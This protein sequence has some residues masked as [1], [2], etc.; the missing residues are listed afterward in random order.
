MEADKSGCS[1]LRPLTC[2]EFIRGMD[3]GMDWDGIGDRNLQS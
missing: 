2:L 3:E 1:K